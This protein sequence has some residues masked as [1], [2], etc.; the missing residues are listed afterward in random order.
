MVDIPLVGDYQ[1]VT[2]NRPVLVGGS[3]LGGSPATSWIHFSVMKASLRMKVTNDDNMQPRLENCSLT[4]CQGSS[5]KC[6]SEINL[7]V[8]RFGR[9][10][11]KWLIESDRNQLKP[12]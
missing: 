9:D 10:V 4:L 7:D 6:Q 11:V 3:P 2:L 5:W 12:R 8:A 1:S